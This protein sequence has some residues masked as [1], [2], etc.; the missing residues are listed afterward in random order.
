M[1]RQITI[2]MLMLLLNN[3]Q[4]FSQ[5]NLQ[6]N[7]GSRNLVSI[8]FVDK[9]LGFAA[10]SSTILKTTDGGITWVQKYS[11][12]VNFIF[13][14][15]FSNNNGVAVGNSGKTTVIFKSTNSGENWSQVGIWSYDASYAS[16]F[17]SLSVG[18]VA[19]KGYIQKTT[20][21]G[22]NWISQPTDGYTSLWSI[23]ML[24]GNYGW[25]VGNNSMEYRTTD[26]GTN[27][28][29]STIPFY[30]RIMQSVFFVS[31]TAGWVVDSQG[32]IA[33]SFNG[34]QDW[35]QQSLITN[36]NY[37]DILFN[38][39]LNGWLCGQSSGAG[40][41]LR[42]TNAGD[43]WNNV[44]IP[45][46]YSLHGIWSIDNN[47]VWVVGDSGKIISNAKR[48]YLTSPNGGNIW[49]AGS[50]QDITWK[51]FNITN[52]KI[53]L[54]TDDGISWQTRANSVSSSSNSYSLTVPNYP[55]SNCRI[56]I[57][58]ASDTT[59][60]DVSETKFTIQGIKVQSPNGAEI[61]N[62]NTQQNISWTSAGVNNLK[63]DYTTN[64][65]TNWLPV[66]ASTPASSGSY[67]WTV[68]NTPS[69]QCKVRISDASNS[70]ISGISDNTF[71][72]RGINI[73]APNGG[74]YWVIKTKQNIT[75]TSGGISNVKIEY[76]T[77]N[78]T[79]WATVIATTP[80]SSGSYNW[81]IPYAPSTQCKVRISDVTDT[82]INGKSANVFTIAAVPQVTIV[83]PNGGE[84]WKVGEIDTV[85]WTSK[86]VTNVKIEYTINNEASWT[87]IIDTT[88][89]SSRSY[90][91]TV[92]DTP[93]TQSKIRISD[94]S[95]PTVNSKSANVFN[96]VMPKITIVSP[97]GGENWYITKIDTIKWT[98]SHVN[99]A[100]IEYTTNNGTGWKTVI[101][102]IPASL[103]SYPWTIPNELSNQCKVRI[104]DTSN[105]SI[106]DTS[107]NTF[108]ISEQPSISV[109]SPGAGSI[110]VVGTQQTVKWSTINVT[111]NL[112]IKLSTN[113]GST[114]PITLISNTPNDSSEVI[115]VPNDSS[116]TYRVLVESV[117]NTSVFGLSN[118]NFT[119]VIPSIKVITP[120]GGEVCDT[121]SICKITWGSKYVANVK[122]EYSING[123]GS[124]F[125]ID[126]SY[127]STGIFNWK[128]PNTPSEQCKIKISDTSNGSWY[129]ES[130]SLFII[131]VPTGI[132][133]LLSSRPTQFNLYQNFPNPFNPTSMIRYSL[134]FESKV[135]IKIYN[136]LGQDVKLLK[137]DIVAAGN[138]EVQ[139]NSSNFPSGVYFYQLTAE[140]LDGKQKYSSIKK[141]ILLK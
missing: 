41:L 22:A 128:V 139:F 24:D 118:G 15:F 129:D 77:N 101:A 39:E 140:S 105:S 107:D 54:S 29:N 126:S 131:R 16:Y 121:G 132:R 55:S 113:G 60:N 12:A 50:S 20:D 122:I 104:S 79:N 14:E 30:G 9:D 58:D 133:E 134:P 81:T 112:N 91:W 2:I 70:S 97:N 56:R 115:T 114:F 33:H 40:I 74:E 7:S 6:V 137:D 130:D 10:G 26:G 65:G 23:Y 68:S 64:N 3:I 42:T 111:G 47:N 96:I 25:S 99:N 38:S 59:V 103:G 119:I 5:F 45:S 11:S 94:V 109:T 95:N 120:N 75:F 80:A 110:W 46:V 13:I 73:T 85:K 4:L 106:S 89:A 17:I 93:S 52:L 92:P 43:T 18:W 61:W 28:M 100:K 69:N 141:M 34:G 35:I 125:N 78:G 66:I 82:T 8:Y 108:T 102:S 1:I 138:Y 37:Y 116:S 98:S 71:S 62:V 51:Y 123:G 49:P 44:T 57:S 86:Y 90:P 21:G 83:S 36:N 136:V 135:I 32:L 117:N 127:A 27:W 31:S 88:P 76:S 48:L 72:I 84:Y 87:T 124:W 67:P 63:I 53:E 19:G